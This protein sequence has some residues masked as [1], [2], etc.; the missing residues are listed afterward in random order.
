MLTLLF[1]VTDAI[2]KAKEFVD[3]VGNIDHLRNK[4]IE[5]NKLNQSVSAELK[6]VK[7]HLAKA[8]QDVEAEKQK[9]IDA[10]QDN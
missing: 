7:K 6:S 4:N 8:E 9:G 5:L 2:N 10:L 3:N 1:Y